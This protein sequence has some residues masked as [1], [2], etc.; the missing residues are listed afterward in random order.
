VAHPLQLHRK[1][2]VAF[3]RGD[4]MQRPLSLLLA[5]IALV[6]GSTAQSA[7]FVT[8]AKIDQAS[9][10]TDFYKQGRRFY[11]D[12]TVKNISATPKAVTVW[13]NPAWSWVTNSKDVMT[14]QEA[15]QNVPSSITLKPGEIYRGS[16]EMF[17]DPK[18]KRP[19]TFRLGFI[20][21]AGSPVQDA[22]NPAL[23]WSNSV[24]LAQ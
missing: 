21:D 18:G 16:L 20:P 10:K 2:W 12:V 4:A 23:I 13:T 24:V 6:S 1:G 3:F 14:S 22:Q 11:T 17:A 8:T 7:D 9:L 19:I 5:L 15:L